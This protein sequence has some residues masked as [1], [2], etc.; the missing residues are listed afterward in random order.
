VTPHRAHADLEG[1]DAEDPLLQ[2]DGHADLAQRCDA[3]PRDGL[4]QR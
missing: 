3:H 1:G 2:D 4:V